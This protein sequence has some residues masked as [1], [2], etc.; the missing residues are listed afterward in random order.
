MTDEW[1]E[2]KTKVTA[3]RKLKSLADTLEEQMKTL[4]AELTPLVEAHGKWEDDGGYARLNVRRPYTSYNNKAL[5]AL[6]LS[7][8]GATKLLGPHRTI[9]PGYQYL[10]VK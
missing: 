3:Y 5:E 6:Y 4:K 1:E 8:R 10:Q 2:I 9:K 7:V